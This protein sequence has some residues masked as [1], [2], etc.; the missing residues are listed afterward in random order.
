MASSTTHPLFVQV[1]QGNMPRIDGQLKVT[2][3]ACY[4]SDI[5]LPDMLYA[6]PV[7]ATIAKGSITSLDS[8]RALHMP[9]VK[10]VYSRENIGKLYRTI[11]SQGLG[12]HVDERRPPFEDDII[13]YYGQYVAAVV[14]DSYEQA[15]AAAR[16]VDVNYNIQTPDV[17]DYLE[18]VKKPSIDSFRGDPDKAYAKAAVKLDETYSTPVETHNPMELHA[19]VASWDGQSF[20]LYETTQGVMNSRDALAQMLGVPLENIR[21]ISRFLGSGFGSK[22]WPWPHALIAAAA[23][24]NLMRPV[25][26]VLSRAM[27]FQNVGHRPRTE[28]RVRLGATRTGKLVSLMHD[29]VNHTSMLDDYSEQCTEITGFSYS[30]RNLRATSGQV[31]RN[32][33]APTSMRGPG[34]VPGLYALESALDELAVKLAIDPLDLRLINEPKKDEGL[35]IPF[36]SRHMTECLMLGAKKFG[37]SERNSQ[38]A[39]MKKDQAILGWG[40]ASCSW[41]AER[42]AAA[43]TVD[44]RDDG[45]VRVA[46]ATQDIGTGMYTALAQIVLEKT[47]LSYDKIEVTL[48]DSSLAAGPISGGSFA[49]ASAIPAV[50]QAIEKAQAILLRTATQSKASIFSEHKLHELAFSKGLVHLKNKAPETGVSFAK[51]LSAAQIR[52]VTGRGKS[53]GTFGDPKPKYSKH[54]FGAHFVEV[55]WQPEMARLQ[56]S[57]VTTVIDGGHILNPIPAKNQIEGAIIM[58][59]GMALFEETVYDQRFGLPINNNFADYIVATNADS[60]QIDVTFLDYPD[61][62]INPLGSRGIGEIGLAGIAAAITAAVHHATGIRVRKLP[63]RIEDLL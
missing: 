16:A 40:V 46:C 41:I 6:V 10:A 29:S 21:I 4:S 1:I 3:T 22:L 7:C 17:R 8:S 14:A 62:I 9:G 53:D 39:S 27:M 42:A 38:I 19:T 58:G 48:G 44:F 32:V 52:A 26:L 35:N 37:W 61:T 25:K 5:N 18:P 2:G 51:I 50:L 55:C 15:M 63:V 23:A 30:T 33:G 24:R 13:S 34:A 56:V 36:S 43:A 54:S 31:R 45:T 20:T 59:I 47:G 49:T 28:Q 60:P 57:R 11:P 12:A